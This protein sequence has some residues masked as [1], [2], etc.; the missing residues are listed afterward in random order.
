MSDLVFPSAAWLD[1]WVEVCNDDEE[2]RRAGQG[3]VGTIGAVVSA[4]AHDLASAVYLRLDGRDGRW[5]SHQ[6]STA[7]DAVAD[8]TVTLVAPY[9]VWK[10]VIRQD[11]DPLRA[12]IRGQVRVTGRLSVIL[13][14]VP[15]MRRMTR[16]A[17]TLPTRFP[18]EQS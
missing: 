16:L 4:D 8:A 7:E 15:A 13:G 11:L 14:R 9:D 5:T 17:G 1:R 18:D 12:M 6:I 3:W 2:F 10:S